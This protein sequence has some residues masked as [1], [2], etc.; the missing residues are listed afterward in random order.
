MEQHDDSPEF[1]RVT[2][3]LRDKYGCPIGT[4]SNNSIL[5]TS[6]YKVEYVDNHKASMASN[7][8]ASNLFAQVD[9]DRQQ[10][11]LFDEIIDT[12]TDGN[13]IKKVEAFIQIANIHDI[14]DEPEFAW[15][16][17]HMFKKRD[18]IIY[19]TS[20]RYCQQTHKY[21]IEIPKSVYDSI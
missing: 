1:S 20:G 14:A 11:A 10:F 9:Q 18:R 15:W 6:M 8:I 5:D 17:R 16:I 12:R 2:G 7:A 19:K 3:R 21:C 13:Q 4:A